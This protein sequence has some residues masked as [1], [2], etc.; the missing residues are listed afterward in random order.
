MPLPMHY[1]DGSRVIFR[2]TRPVLCDNGSEW[3]PCYGRPAVTI[4]DH[5]DV[6][7][8]VVCRDCA[9]ALVDKGRAYMATAYTVKLKGPS[10]AV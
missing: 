6:W 4:R 10:Y 1:T 3:E 7:L 5:T 9:D 8:G 2:D